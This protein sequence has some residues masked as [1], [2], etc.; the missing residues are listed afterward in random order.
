MLYSHP[1]QEQI[2]NFNNMENAISVANFFIKKALATGEVVTPM[3]A[4]KLVYISHGWYLGL[5]DEPLINEQ[6]EAWKY[7]PVV[8]SVYYAFRSYGSS[9]ITQLAPVAEPDGQYH[10]RTVSDTSLVPFLNKV[11]D[12]YKELDGLQLSALTHQADTP[13]FKA[14]YKDGGKD[15]LGKPIGNDSIAQHYKELAA[16]NLAKA[17]SA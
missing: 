12:L 17:A 8:P 16:A 5:T 14:W 9:T 7:G 13:W 4:V 11:W 1:I 15:I 2:L 3:K 10:Y 6:I